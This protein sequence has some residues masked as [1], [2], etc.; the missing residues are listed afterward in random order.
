VL[1][2]PMRLILAD[3]SCLVP[4]IIRCRFGLPASANR[5]G[6]RRRLG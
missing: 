4:G 2:L 1:Y 6:G 5:L 3:S